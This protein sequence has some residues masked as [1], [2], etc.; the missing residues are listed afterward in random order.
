MNI[1]ILI[2]VVIAVD[3][4]RLNTFASYSAQRSLLRF[5]AT[6]SKELIGEDKNLC[7]NIINQQ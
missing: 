4:F 5:S 3:C 7:E 2:K 6:P 1:A